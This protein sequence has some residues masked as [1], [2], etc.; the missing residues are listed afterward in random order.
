MIG[1]APNKH[2]IVLLKYQRRAIEKEYTEQTC[3]H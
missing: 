3:A 2:W 1:E